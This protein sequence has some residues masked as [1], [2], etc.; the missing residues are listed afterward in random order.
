MLRA[1]TNSKT[2][3]EIIMFKGLKPIVMGVILIASGISGAQTINNTSEEQI[4]PPHHGGP[5]A[6]PS[7]G[8]GPTYKPPVNPTKVHYPK[9]P[10]GPGHFRSPV[11]H[12]GG[13]APVG[14]P[15][16][17]TIIKPHG[18]PAPVGPVFYK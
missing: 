13:P 2:R 7:K 14:R 6:P 5:M 4:E 10:G 17:G 8:W 15:H 3:G 18:G 9:T 16:G 1:G 11:G 12:H